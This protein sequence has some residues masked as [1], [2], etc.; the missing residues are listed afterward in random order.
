MPIS[1]MLVAM[2]VWG[3]RTTWIAGVLGVLAL[4]ACSVG[5]PEPA[6]TVTVTV[7]PAPPDTVVVTV[8]GLDQRGEVRQDFQLDAATGADIDPENCDEPSAAG[9]SAGTYA[10]GMSSLQADACWR[11]TDGDLVCINLPW[12]RRL[13]LRPMGG[14]LAETDLPEYGQ[15][16]GLQLEDG[17]RYR[18]RN[19][20]GVGNAPDNYTDVYWCAEGP[21]GDDPDKL[22]AVLSGDDPVINKDTNAWTVLV[23]E[24]AKGSTDPATLPKPTVQRVVRAWFITA[25]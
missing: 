22:L 7:T 4:T 3:G 9:V 17:S 12:E 8:N 1:V 11:R 19:G 20:T 23:G 13:Y 5:V 25:E 6:P 14:E 16:L 10:C 15:P 21:C 2:A 24:L 18:Q